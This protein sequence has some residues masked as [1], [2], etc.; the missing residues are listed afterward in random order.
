MEMWSG[1]HAGLSYFRDLL[2]RCYLRTGSN[3]DPAAVGVQRPVTAVVRDNAIAAIAATLTHCCYRAIRE[4][5]N[6]RAAVGSNIQAI[7]KTP[8]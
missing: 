5:A 4:T 7:V 3:G 6:G 8:Y 2:P 1:S